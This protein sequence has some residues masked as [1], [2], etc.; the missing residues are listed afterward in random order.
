MTTLDA[1]GWPVERVTALCRLRW[2]I[3]LAFKQLK[4]QARLADLRAKELQLARSRILAKRILALLADRLAA[5][6]RR[7]FWVG[8]PLAR[9]PPD[10]A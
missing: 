3:E 10:G 9:R 1:A 7:P 4:S 5:G 8:P 6:L 2:Q